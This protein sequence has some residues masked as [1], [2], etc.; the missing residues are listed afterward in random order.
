VRET[1]SEDFT[2]PNVEH[3]TQKP[4]Y[5]KVVTLKGHD[6]LKE[7]R[8]TQVNKEIIHSQASASDDDVSGY[9]TDLDIEKGTY[10]LVK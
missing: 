5:I 9:E 4:I 10:T 8:N 6:V 2:D 7:H 3:A 1:S